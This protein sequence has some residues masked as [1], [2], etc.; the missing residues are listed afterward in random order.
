MQ[1][2]LVPASLAVALAATQASAALDPQ[3]VTVMSAITPS[4]FAAQVA[5][6]LGGIIVIPAMFIGFRLLRKALRQVG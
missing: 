2:Y 3:I 4:D 5:T 1:K 6:L